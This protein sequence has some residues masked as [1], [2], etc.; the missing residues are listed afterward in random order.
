[1]P[2][3][4]NGIL[5]SELRPC[6]YCFC[7]LMAMALLWPATAFSQ[8]TDEGKEKITLSR[9]IEIAFSNN[10]LLKGAEASIEASKANT[11]ASLSAFFP[12]LNLYESL[13]R[14]NNPPMVFT[15]K[16]AQERFTSADFGID[17]LNNPSPMTNWQS[18]FVL[19]QPIF[20]HG[21]EIIGYR[22]S[23]V[24]EQISRIE[25][26]KLRQEISFQVEKAYYQV[27]LAQD[28]LEVLKASVDT[29]RAMK[30]L[31]TKREKA[32]LA[33]KSDV[34]SAE[35]NLVSA[36][37]ERLRAEGNVRI[38]MA[39][40]NKAI[41]VSQDRDWEIVAPELS[42]GLLSRD[43]DT[44]LE[45]ARRNRPEILVSK[46]MIEAAGLKTREARFQF[47]PSLNLQGAYE[48]NTRDFAGSDGD[49]WSL[50]AI[51]SF[52]I[53]NGLGDRARLAAASAEERRTVYQGADID[54]QV[55]FEVRQAYFNLITAKK[56]LDV[57]SRAVVQAE[58]TLRILKKRYEN[59]LALM[60]EV[61]SAE[62][63]LKETRLQE[64]QAR[65][66]FMTAMS[67]LKLKTGVL[68]SEDER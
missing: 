15:H 19:T 52:N 4:Q 64:A 14:T 21:R 35:V 9:A 10:P 40:L 8:G 34:L 50:M 29:A 61:L 68:E 54:A 53:F 12:S 49:S 36:E 1:M 20:N 44:W 42:E 57:V 66:D 46:K 18:R 26:T 58:E 65:F 41:G 43:M 59:G 27:I 38:A 62:T 32:G 23:K 39:A 48:A 67:D 25:K 51:M 28:C 30:E 37:R 16:L 45:I 11:L 31:A 63:T 5:F 60:V 22:L 17:S 47:L 13:E 33:L 2:F 55:G 56:Q 3:S 7:F 24:Q 6:L